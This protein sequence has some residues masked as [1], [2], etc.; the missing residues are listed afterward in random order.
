M[1][2][3]SVILCS[4]ISVGHDHGPLRLGTSDLFDDGQHSR[5]TRTS[6]GQQ[7]RRVCWRQYEVTGR[8]TDI[9]QISELDMIMEVAGNAAVWGPV[10]S[11]DP[12][13]GDLQPSPYSGGRHRVLPGL[14]VTVGQV[15][16]N[17]D[18][19]SGC[20]RWE[21]TAVCWFEDESDDV[22]GFLYAADHAVGASRLRGVHVRLLVE[23]C[24]LGDQLEREQPIDLAPG[25]G[26]LGRNGIAENLSDGSEQILA[27]NRVLLGADAQ[28]YVLVGDS[29]HDVIK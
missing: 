22:S 10:R 6:A 2:S 29:A 11:L 14:P 16:E 15:D 23:P 20:D 25:R 8:G 17:R 26:D 28:G 19:L 4:A 9:E 5:D 13:H 21:G 3:Q 18:V 24:F 27:D 7:Q 1:S 12:P